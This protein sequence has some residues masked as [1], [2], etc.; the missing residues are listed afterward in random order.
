MTT[1]F[2]ADPRTAYDNPRHWEYRAEEMRTIAD[3]MKKPECKRIM[4]EN[5][6]AYERL[7]V[8]ASRRRAENIRAMA[9]AGLANA[10][11][12]DWDAILR[13]AI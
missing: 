9:L 11:N 4:L 13:A 2:K 5:A 1:D 12:I 10:L 7:G 6:A 3:Q 8:W